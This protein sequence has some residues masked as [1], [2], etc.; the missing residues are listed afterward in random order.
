MILNGSKRIIF[1][2]S[3]LEL[4]QMVSKIYTKQCASD[5]AGAPKVVDCEI[6]DRLESPIP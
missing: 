3:G 2:S 6:Q 4:L 5:D 1:A